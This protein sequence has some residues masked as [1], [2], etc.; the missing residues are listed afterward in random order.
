M[1]PEQAD[2]GAPVIKDSSPLAR[3]AGSFGCLTAPSI[4][5][6]PGWSFIGAN[7]VACAQQIF[8]MSVRGI[9]NNRRCVCC[10]AKEDDSTLVSGKRGETT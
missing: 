3:A 4:H 8:N 1:L 7:F 10:H 6:W 5:A 2:H 9:T